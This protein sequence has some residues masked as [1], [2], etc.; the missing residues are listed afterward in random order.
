MRNVDELRQHAKEI[1]KQCEDRK[2]TIEDTRMLLSVLKNEIS[3]CEEA[4]K[5]N[6]FKALAR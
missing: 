6:M 2:Y 3:Q 1:A 4:Y 5:N